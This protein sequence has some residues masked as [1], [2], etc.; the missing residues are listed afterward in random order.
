MCMLSGAACIP[1]VGDASVRN[2]PSAVGL[3]SAI[4]KNTAEMAMFR[5]DVEL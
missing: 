3:F 4:A 1:R 2:R 5:G